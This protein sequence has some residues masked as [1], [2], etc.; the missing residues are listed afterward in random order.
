MS[1][2][3]VD[4]LPGKPGAGGAFRGAAEPVVAQRTGLTIGERLRLFWYSTPEEPT[5][6]AARRILVTP[7]HVYVQ[8]VDGSLSRVRHDALRGERVEPGGR[9]VIGVRDDE[10]LLLPHRAGCEAEKRLIAIVRGEAAPEPW[11]EWRGV[12]LAAVFTIG[13][14][15]LG[16]G[17]LIQYPIET[18]VEHVGRGLYTSESALGT[19]GG[20]AGLLAALLL[21]FFGGSRWQVDAVGVTRGR[22][23]LGWMRSIVPPERFRRAVLRPAYVKPKNRARYHAGWWVQLELREKGRVGTLFPVKSVSLGY[24]PFEHPITPKVRQDKTAEAKQLADR[25]TKLLALTE[26]VEVQPAQRI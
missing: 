2:E 13:A 8:R 7:Q 21:F 1:W 25:L 17:L 20:A 18:M 3:D 22:G 15:A 6:R 16:T 19:Y 10:D 9:L 24:F 5:G 11:R 4:E 14:F 12:I 26:D 23:I